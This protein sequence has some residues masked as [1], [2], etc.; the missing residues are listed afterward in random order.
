MKMS[1]TPTPFHQMFSLT[2]RR[3]GSTYLPPYDI[4]RYTFDGKFAAVRAHVR[5][6]EPANRNVRNPVC[7]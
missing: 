2:H 5:E 4:K 1:D 6:I 7:A 3:V